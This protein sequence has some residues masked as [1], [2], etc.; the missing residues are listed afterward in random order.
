LESV[1]MADVRGWRELLQDGG[2]TGKTCNKYVKDVGSAFRAAIREGL[3]SHNPCAAL[4]S[5]SM[6]DSL[7]RKPFTIAE[8]VSL[9][10]AAPSEQW[11]GLILA[12]AFT[13]LRLGDAARLSWSSVDLAGKTITLMP[14]KT[15]KK[16]RTVTIPI[17]PDLLAYFESLSIEDDSPGAPVFPKLSQIANSSGSGLSKAFEKIMKAANVDR[18]KAS[19]ETGE[20]A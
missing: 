7:D 10:T 4:E 20:G 14:S 1:T 8:V 16:K 17:Q 9:V 19:R 12:A 11:R 3:V 2:R 15:K 5:V 13:G 18:G 6:E